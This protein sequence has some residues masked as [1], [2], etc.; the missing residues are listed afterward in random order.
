VH[1]KT[2]TNVDRWVRVYKT[3]GWPISYFSKRCM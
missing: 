3:G 2:K 1:L